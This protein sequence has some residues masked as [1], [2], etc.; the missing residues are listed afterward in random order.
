[1]IQKS[2]PKTPP[3]G[4]TVVIGVQTA[5]LLQTT[6]ETRNSAK[7]EN[8]NSNAFG[9]RIVIVFVL[10]MW[11]MAWETFGTNRKR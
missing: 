3:Q 1:M 9:A 8:P 10:A 6:L 11:G 5:H 7:Q 2:A 4:N